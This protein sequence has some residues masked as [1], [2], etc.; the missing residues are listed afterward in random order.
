[1]MVSFIK[2]EWAHLAD[3]DVIFWMARQWGIALR[4][5][6]QGMPKVILY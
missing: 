6:G 2:F 3:G 1:M 4:K 5:V